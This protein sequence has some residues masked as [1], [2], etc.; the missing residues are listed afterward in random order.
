MAEFLLK[1][2]LNIF[3][4]KKCELSIDMA[5]LI[6]SKLNIDDIVAW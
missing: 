3:E 5:D 2:H 1:I 6:N 4:N